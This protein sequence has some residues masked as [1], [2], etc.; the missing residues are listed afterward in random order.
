MD[1][2]GYQDLN[3][4][5]APAR[6]HAQSVRVSERKLQGA[7]RDFGM[8]AGDALGAAPLPLRDSVEDA[9]MLVAR[10]DEDV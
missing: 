1:R 3:L 6:Q 10:D 4:N 9:E 2:L 8:F 5:K 7:A